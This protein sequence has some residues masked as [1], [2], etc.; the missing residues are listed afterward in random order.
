MTRDRIRNWLGVLAAVAFILA[1]MPFYEYRGGTVSTQA[2]FDHVR[3]NPGDLPYTE[4][5]KFGWHFSPLV[6][7]HRAKTL[8]L[9]DGRLTVGGVMRTEV[10]WVSWSG[11][12]LGVGVGLLWAAK[13]LKPAPQPVS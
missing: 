2:E 3:A 5:Y 7:H 6:H 8:R 12:T 13:R 9:I 11:L 10:N 1:V 4:D